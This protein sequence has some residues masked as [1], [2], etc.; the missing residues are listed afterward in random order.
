[1]MPRRSSAR[2]RL[3]LEDLR[4]N[5]IGALFFVAVLFRNFGTDSKHRP[6]EENTPRLCDSL[7]GITEILT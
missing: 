3:T 4:H 5:I 7:L 1:M 6:E 2:E